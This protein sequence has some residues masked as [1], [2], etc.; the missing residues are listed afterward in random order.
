[1][2]YRFGAHTMRAVLASFAGLIVSAASADS[3]S[4][5]NL[6]VGGNLDSTTEVE[7]RTFVRGNLT[8]PS[9]NYATMLTPSSNYQGVDTLLV[10]GNINVT[11]INVNAGNVRLG[12]S[13]TGN[14]NLNGV[15]GTLIHDSSVALTGTGF[16]TQMSNVSSLLAGLTPNS[17]VSIPIGQP[18]PVTFNASPSGPDNVAVFSIPAGL[19]SNVLVQQYNL[20]ANGA[21]SIIINVVGSTVNYNQGN[22]VGAWT[23]NAVRATTMWNF[24]DATNIAFDRQFN[25]A[26]LA[27]L[28]NLSNSGPIEGSTW[29]G[30]NFTQRGEVHLPNYGGYVPEPASLTLLAIGALTMLRRR[31]A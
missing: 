9:S 19:L 23:T 3:F 31:S 4:S 27:P 1:M 20:N 13:Q 8:G 12:G 17:N 15:G 25:G 28:A 29:I 30:G 6:Y 16:L 10:G 11:N 18:G 24:I 7:G 26:V 5:F 22:F 21:S 2:H 14:V